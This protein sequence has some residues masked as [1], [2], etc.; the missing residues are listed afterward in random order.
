MTR[1][2]MQQYDFIKYHIAFVN[3]D[4]LDVSIDILPA[5]VCPVSNQFEEFESL[6]TKLQFQ[7][8]LVVPVLDSNGIWVREYL[9][10][11]AFCADTYQ[12]A[13]Q[14]LYDAVLNKF[15][16]YTEEERGAKIDAIFPTSVQ[17]SKLSETILHR[18]DPDDINDY[19]ESLKY[20][21]SSI[22]LL[23]TTLMNC[24]NE[25]HRE[26]LLID[27]ESAQSRKFLYETSLKLNI[28]AFDY[29]R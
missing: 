3:E 13:L 22:T 11:F 2:V 9:V 23:E 8:D 10:N 29:E 16:D 20:L 15:G 28:D 12:E 26:H 24:T 17:V 19:N 21:E 1:T 25:E 27:L 6:N 18:L 14:M 7:T 5:M 4:F